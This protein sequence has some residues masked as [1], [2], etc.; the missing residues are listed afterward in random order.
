M[1]DAWKRLSNSSP[2]TH[3]S[4]STFGVFA[5]YSF[6]S[7]S[8]TW[9]SG[10]LSRRYAA[11]APQNPAPATTTRL[12]ALPP[13]VFIDRGTDGVVP[14]RAISARSRSSD[15]VSPSR[16]FERAGS[17][18]ASSAAAPP[19][20]SATAATLEDS[21]IPGAADSARTSS[22]RVA[23]T[24]PPFAT[25]SRRRR[26]FDA[27]TAA[28]SSG[29][30]FSSWS[31]LRSPLKRA[32]SRSA[33]SSESL[34]AS[35]R[36]ARARIS[37]AASAA[38]SAALSGGGAASAAAAAAAAWAAGGAAARAAAVGISATGSPIAAAPRTSFS[39][40]FI[41]TVRRGRPARGSKKEN[42]PPLSRSTTFCWP[43]SAAALSS[44][45]STSC[46]RTDA[47]DVVAPTRARPASG[48]SAAVPSR[49]A[50][51]SASASVASTTG[52]RLSSPAP[53]GAA[54]AAPLDGAA[55]GSVRAASARRI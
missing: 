52:T 22:A 1:C 16:T 8:V 40:A 38:A 36:A 4:R 51:A 15:G 24:S 13:A 49:S 25:A 18:A 11:I 39:C 7:S 50:A 41:T 45:A 20:P 26:S 2:A 37:D 47:I 14:S 34:S 53:L 12:R 9:S 29:A 3:I 21:P 43:S 19:A 28:S 17:S 30:P 10:I 5:M 42:L 55:A 46:A 33:S 48:S 32:G 44:I 23:G 35:F 54:A 27:S 31:I 6:V